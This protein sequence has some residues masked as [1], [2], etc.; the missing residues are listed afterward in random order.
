MYHS[1]DT[2]PAIK[3]KQQEI[4]LAKSMEER[5][6]LSLQMI[7]DARSLQLHGI[8][9]RYPHWTPTQIMHYLL[10]K[11]AQNDPSLHWLKARLTPPA[12]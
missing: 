9:L 10:W 1:P 7:D 3:K 5:L 4:W 2:P 6:C 12:F 8:A 11:L